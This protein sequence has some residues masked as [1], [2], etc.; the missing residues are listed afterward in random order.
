MQTTIISRPVCCSLHSPTEGSL[1]FS[2]YRSGL[3]ETVRR[4]WGLTETRSEENPFFLSFP[5]GTHF[6]IRCGSIPILSLPIYSSIFTIY[7]ALERFLGQ[8][9]AVAERQDDC[10]VAETRL[11]ARDGQL[12]D[13]LAIGVNWPSGEWQS[14]LNPLLN[15]EAISISRQSVLIDWT[16]STWWIIQSRS[17][18]VIRE[19]CDVCGD[20]Q[21][22]P[23][24]VLEWKVIHPQH[25][26]NWE[27]LPC[28]F[29]ALFRMS[30]RQYHGLRYLTHFPF[31]INHELPDPTEKEST[32]VYWFNP[33]RWSDPAQAALVIAGL[34]RGSFSWRRMKNFRGFAINLENMESSVDTDAVL[35]HWVEDRIRNVQETN[36]TLH[37]ADLLRKWLLR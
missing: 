15:T 16:T 2:R 21:I 28:D 26:V 33:S 11:F 35:V 22:H 12:H 17:D 31:G 5:S 20:E 10:M 18:A 23:V 37:P 29:P 9:N 8:P 4:L 30:S 25:L 32:S 24:P 36:R 14:S 34:I 13:Q 27:K 6:Q 1:D 19:T 3:T 7:T